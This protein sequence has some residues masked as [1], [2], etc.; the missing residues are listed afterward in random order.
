[1]KLKK[2]VLLIFLLVLFSTVVCIIFAKPVKATGTI[3]IKADGSIAPSTAPIQREGNIYMFTD[4]IREEIVVEKD[5]IVL[6]G[7]DYTLQGTVE[8]IPE[9]TGISLSY[10]K[11]VTIKNM[12]IKKFW[13]GIVLEYAS[14][15]TI[16]GNTM[17]SNHDAVFLGHSSENAI[18]GNNVKGSFAVGIWL[19]HSSNNSI[20]GNI[21]CNNYIGIDLSRCCD[22]NRICGN[23]VTSSSVFS[24]GISHSFNNII[25]HNDIVGNLYIENTTNIWDDGTDKGNYWSLYS[26]VDQDGDGIGDTPCVIDEN[27]QDDYPLMD[28]LDPLG[29]PEVPFWMQW[30]FWAIIA[31]VIVALAGAAYLLKKGKPQITTVP[32]LPPEGI[33]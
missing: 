9:G 20:C 26:G 12:A 14:N 1:M 32:P 27:N 13:H 25:H 19:L 18:S 21:L 7:A 8:R 23:T 5:D 6:D 24:I 16:S 3:Y 4:N 2:I 31:V 22:S 29:T 17:T 11:N 10:R 30:W 28:P 15:N 33:T